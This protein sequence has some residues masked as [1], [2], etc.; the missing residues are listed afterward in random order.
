MACALI[1]S[2]S[3]KIISCQNVSGFI[4]DVTKVKKCLVI[5]AS[6]N[7]RIYTKILYLTSIFLINSASKNKASVSNKNYIKMKTNKK[8]LSMLQKYVPYEALCYSLYMP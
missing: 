2:R 7:Q 1:C 6:V 8:C 4:I 5:H 3:V